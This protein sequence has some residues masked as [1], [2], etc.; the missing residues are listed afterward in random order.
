[1]LNGAQYAVY[2]AGRGDA[3][4]MLHGF[5]GTHRTWASYF[6]NLTQRYQVIAPDLLGH[7]NTA[8]PRSPERYRIEYAAADLIALID[9]LDLQRVYLLGYSMGGRLALYTAIHYPDRIAALMLESASPGL[10]TD[11][12]RADRNQRDNALADRIER[13]GITAFVN[14]WEAL[15]L[16]N[17]QKNT[18]TEAARQQLRDER[19][20][21]RPS[22]LANS[23]RGMGT[24]VQPPLWD[25]L[26]SL[27]MFVHLVA[28]QLDTKFLQL[29]HGMLTLLPHAFLDIVPDAG[30]AV[31]LERSHT[32]EEFILN[33]E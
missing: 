22:G 30:H 32:F 29:N 1:M 16:W 11:K 20:G 10:R 25:K 18:L 13:N 2:V 21:Q 7:G 31:H 15:P 8:A 28:G 12:E 3:L 23:L 19:L 24:G 9:E 6:P 17:S 5:T 4:V 27:N 33:F 14:E 26:S